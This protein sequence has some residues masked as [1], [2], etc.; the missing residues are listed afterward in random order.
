M[1]GLVEPQSSDVAAIGTAVHAAI[2]TTLKGQ[3]PKAMEA[4][5]ESL[6]AAWHG[7][8]L[9]TVTEVG[10]QAE[11]VKVSWRIYGRWRAEI[12]PELAGLEILDIERKFTVPVVD[13]DRHQINLQGTYDALDNLG[14]VWDWKTGNRDVA[15][16]EAWKYRRGYASAQHIIYPWAAEVIRRDDNPLE[17]AGPLWHQFRYCVIPRGGGNTSVLDLTV[18]ADD[19]RFLLDEITRICLLIEADLPAWPLGP[20]DWHC[21]PKWCP[22]WSQCRGKHHGQTPW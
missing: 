19:C 11:A 5:E 22:A 3:G 14:R 21:S 20:T 2:E 10:S 4:I 15:G 9:L 6:E 12:L 18:T 1:L 8:D 17:M 16:R 7:P 13:N